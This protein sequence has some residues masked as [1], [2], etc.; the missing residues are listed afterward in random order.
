MIEVRDIE[1]QGERNLPIE[2]KKD[3]IERTQNQE[4]KSVLFMID[5]ELSMNGA[6]ASRVIYLAKE[7]EKAGLPVII[8]GIE[9]EEKKEESYIN[10]AITVKKRK[11]NRLGQMRSRF[12]LIRSAARLLREKRIGHIIVRGY[13]LAFMMLPILKLYKVR[14]LYDFHGYSYHV[15]KIKGWKIRP[16]ISKF[17]QNSCLSRYNNVITQNELNIELA[18]HKNKNVIFLDNG[19]NIE[20]FTRDNG[21]RENEGKQILERYG[22]P[23][24]KVLVGFVAGTMGDWVDLQCMLDASTLFP[25]SVHLVIVGEGR[26]IDSIDRFLYP[27]ATFTGRV[28]N[29]DV[30]M[31]LN[32]FDICA[33]AIIREYADPFYGSPRKIREW[34][35]MELPIVM[36]DTRPK[37]TYLEEG[38]NAL[39]CKPE[40][41]N[42]MAE[43]IIYLSLDPD[44]RKAMRDRSGEIKRNLSWEKSVNN[45]G[46]IDI[47]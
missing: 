35:A 6:M 42:D 19:V 25:D 21:M 20:R 44:L 26:R 47:F 2:V 7:L 28:K 9:S 15:Q 29:I 33:Y 34:I 16:I 4:V 43:K 24:D 30:K 27:R 12:E 41:P 14:G 18:L 31:L 1:N 39:F 37:P 11:P 23:Q 17:L 45:S 36:T 32:M 40:D 8:L 13:I 3:R 5:C 38:K 22:I 46:I 10:N